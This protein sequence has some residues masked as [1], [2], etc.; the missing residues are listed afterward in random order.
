MSTS[1]V[2]QQHPRTSFSARFPH[3]RFALEKGAEEANIK[4]NVKTAHEETEVP[5]A[6]EE[7][8]A[9]L[10]SHFRISKHCILPH[11]YMSKSN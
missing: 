8:E 4:A 5:S 10:H 7:A 1:H 3:V 6:Q 11:F 2:S 9:H